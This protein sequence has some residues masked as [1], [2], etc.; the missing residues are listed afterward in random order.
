MNIGD[1]FCKERKN[2]KLRQFYVA[3]KV[4]IS[5]TYLSGIERGK[6]IPTLN[7]V[8]LLCDFYA[9]PLWMILLNDVK[10][11]D[12]PE[13]KIEAFRKLMA[14]VKQLSEEFYN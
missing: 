3:E 14:G 11:K 1:V 12:I 13:N 4:G 9:K 2:L 6:K 7:V 5:Q 10:E 8:Q